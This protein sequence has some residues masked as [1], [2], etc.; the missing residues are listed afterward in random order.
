MLDMSRDN[1]AFEADEAG[2]GWNGAEK[3]RGVS[4]KS[5]DD[6]VTLET[7][8]AIRQRS[9]RSASVT[10]GGGSVGFFQPE[11]WP[12]YRPETRPEVPF[13]K[14]TCTNFQF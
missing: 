8:I 4:A 6:E 11:I 3:V 13:K 1:K 12:Q 10:E 2:G 9:G 14:D 5:L 7:K